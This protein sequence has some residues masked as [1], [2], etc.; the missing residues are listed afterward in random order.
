M[1]SHVKILRKIY[2]MQ[3]KFAEQQMK[4]DWR[5]LL[6]KTKRNRQHQNLCPL[7]RPLQAQKVEEW[8]ILV[9]KKMFK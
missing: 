1:V 5:E 2:A 7:K 6:K 8:P 3:L 4:S 9:I